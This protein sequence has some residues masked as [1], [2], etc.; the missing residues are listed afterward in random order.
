MV[1]YPS[2]SRIFYVDVGTTTVIVTVTSSGAAVKEWLSTTRFIHHRRRHRLVVGVGVQRTVEETYRSYPP[3]DTLQLCVGRRC[4][5]F[6]LAH[7]DFIP[8]VLRKFLLNPS[9]TF[10]GFWNQQ[11]AK[12]LRI[13][14]H[15]LQMWRTPLDV[16]MMVAEEEG[17]GSELWKAKREIIIRQWLGFEDVTFSDEI[18]RSNWGREVLSYDQ[19]VQSCR[20]AFCA[21]L[22]GRNLRAW[23][24][25]RSVSESEKKFTVILNLF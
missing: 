15:S 22:I 24:L 20:D 19:I 4:L 11:D 14:R 7:A 21:F 16:R 5:I 6:Q 12:R 25:P 1:L 13:C 9:N 8:A 17:P 10:V 23:D 2:P 18:G 3:A